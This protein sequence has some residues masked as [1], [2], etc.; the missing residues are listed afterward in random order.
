MRLLGSNVHLHPFVCS[1][2]ICEVLEQMFVMSYSSL[3]WLRVSLNIRGNAFFM[4]T[5]GTPIHFGSIPWL[6]NCFSNSSM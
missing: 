6:V 2:A 3:I 1:V 5:P 4:L